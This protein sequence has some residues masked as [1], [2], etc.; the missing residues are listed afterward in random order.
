MTQILRTLALILAC[1]LPM[2][3]AAQDDDRGI[4]QGFLEDNLSDAGRTVRI[5]G[6]AGALSRRATVEAITIADR[7]GVWLEIE[8][9]V[10]DW[11]RGQLFSGVLDI[12]ELSATQI[13]LF[14]P[15]VA[16]ESLPQPE[17]S[18]F[19]LPELPVSIQ[20]GRL[21]VARLVLGE[22]LL[23]Q[24]A[25]LR[26]NGSASLANR[27]G[28]TAI[29]VVRIDGS[30][31]AV[32]LSGS[33]SNVSDVL[34]IDLD[35]SEGPGGIAA[36]LLGLP[37]TPAI[38]LQ[39]AGEDPISDF[40]ADIALQTDGARRLAGQV[41]LSQDDDAAQR[42]AAELGGDIR[43]LVDDQYHAFLG[44]DVRLVTRGAQSADGRLT[45]ET[46][47]LQ[48]EALDLQGALALNADGWPER[49]S[50]TGEITSGAAET[51]LLPLSGPE[52]RVRSVDLTL[53][54]D[55]ASGD[56][57]QLAAVLDR[58]T[59]DGL[60]LE[61][62]EI[63][64]EGRLR[65]GLE[66]V[67]GRL[68]LA[69][70]GIDPADAALAAAIGSEL[71]GG[72]SFDWQKGAPLRLT[73]MA[74]AGADYRLSGDL[75]AAGI[76]GQVELGLTLDARLDAQDLARF[77]SLTG[78]DLEGVAA[79]SLSG[80][81]FPVSGAF[82]LQVAGETQDLALG[83]AQLDPLIAG[84][85]ELALDAVRDTGG[86]RLRGLDLQSAAAR[87]TAAGSV[88]TGASDLEYSL[89]LVNLGDVIT[90][91][92]GPA[93][94]EGT[95]TQTGDT[96]RVT[97]E[98]TAPGQV[99]GQIAGRIDLTGGTPGPATVEAALRIGDARAYAAFFDL[100]VSGALTLEASGAGDIAEGTFDLALESVAQDVAIGQANVDRLLR[101]R[102]TLRA[103]VRGD[104]DLTL[105]IER[106]TLQNAAL[107][108]DLSGQLSRASASLRYEVA[109]NDLR[110][111]E[112]RLS[113]A[114]RAAGRLSGSEQPDGMLWQVTSDLS[115]PGQTDGQVKGSL[116]MTEG[117]AGPVMGD[118]RLNVRN[119]SAY[120]GLAGL[121]VGG[122]LNL[123]VEG[124]GD[125]ST[126]GFE[127][128]LAAEGQDLGIGQ[129][130]VD[131]LLRGR[132]NVDAELRQSG[133][134]ITLQTVTLRSRELSA[135]LSGS[136]SPSQTR[137][138][139][140]VTLR[141]LG[142]FVPGLQ[143]ALGGDGTLTGA[144]SGPLIVASNF[145]GPGGTT[146]R[147]SGSVARDGAGGDLSVTGRAPLGLANRFIEPNL[148]EGPAAFDLRLNGPFALS[149][150]SGQVQS[151]GARVTIP[152]ARI[153]LTD[154][155][156]NA[157]LGGGR[158]EITAGAGVTSGGRLAVRGGAGMSPP[159]SADLAAEIIGLT[160]VEPGFYETR[161]NGQMTVRGPLQGGAAIAGL[162][163]LGET[164]IRIPDGFGGADGALPG[165]EHK[166]DRAA[167]RQTR[168]RAGLDETGASA[169]G[170]GGG[171]AAAY[172]LDITVNAPARIFVR[173]RGLDAEFG[174]ALRLGGTTAKVLTEGRFELIRGR[175][176]ILGK[177]LTL[178]EALLQLEGSFDPF[179]R[180][181]AQTRVDDTEIEIIVEGA[182]SAPSVTF[183]S[184][185]DLPEEEI[186][187]RLLFGRDISEISALQALQLANAVRVLAGRGGE[188]VVGRLRQNFGLDDLDI[189]QTEDGGASL[190]VGRYIS[191]NA[192]TDVTVDSTGRSEIN[193]NLSV[194]PSISLRGSAGSDGDTS[195]GIFFE[196]DY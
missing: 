188:G 143:G 77:A 55:A 164:E 111:V 195:L 125:L 76:E 127:A 141:D 104:R 193:L 54:Y 89:R 177:R 91:A 158:V 129:A 61:T 110:L 3:L 73:E 2:P 126:R 32:R 64:G 82:D 132:S 18:G 68:D 21:S 117:Q 105:E 59:R 87:I 166:G 116:L 6:F 42:F 107:A 15:P 179:I 8:N 131:Q 69:L 97:S 154:L 174:G 144:A 14:R 52:A 139:Y 136:L 45:L 175:L 20:V 84:E 53:G 176:D 183:R 48:S 36:S 135:D 138:S 40:R 4:L 167:V 124:S 75:E 168:A 140:G 145:Q 149:S 81:V 173:G 108:A 146:A 5:E 178:T 70:A 191:D 155:S 66:T 43:P 34:S 118:A 170:S 1:F 134:R 74:L 119:L 123:T 12:E 50:L 17:A 47:S 163:G 26:L 7:D 150:L 72:L 96:W 56:T 106:F 120:R 101:G 9:A 60:A 63:T 37:G 88:A 161:L 30:E 192:Y 133:D 27:Q 190:S 94:L 49:L 65:P 46:L 22:A 151:S 128:R 83:I 31:G 121:A 102:T 19:S 182:A 99:S 186:L 181:V 147:V 23:G 41:V 80:Q 92:D 169:G 157:Q 38:A 10:L 196:R 184:N 165:L 78:Q 85:T 86:L 187:A 51:I 152:D 112:P 171:G 13:T 156:L 194:S 25:E 162:L 100:P 58:F 62:A 71:S 189:T 11:N 79:L 153:G 39:I 148:I 159:Y 93:A 115:A 16:E 95:A 67:N 130:E 57:W 122:A 142:L 160:V 185:P 137:V 28:E 35:V 98:V 90:G 24:A 33:F 109:L 29:E 113:G 44:S 172:P 103:D 180:T 114:A